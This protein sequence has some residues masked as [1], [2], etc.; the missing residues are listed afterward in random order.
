MLKKPTQLVAARAALEKAE[1]D[2]GDPGRLVY[3]RNAIQV[4]LQ[5]MSGVSPQIEKDIARKQVLISRN[6]VLS[7]VK[8]VVAACD[9]YE[10]GILEHW[11]KVMEVFIDAGLGN[12]AE[13]KACKERLVP[14]R[15]KAADLDVEKEPQAVDSEHGGPKMLYRKSL[16]AIGQSLE[17]LRVQTFK[18]EKEGGSY[19][20]RSDSLTLTHQWFLKNSLTKDVSDTTGLNQKSTQ[21][22]GGD[23]WLC[24]GPLDI[25]RLDAQGQRKRDD[26]QIPGAHKLG[27]CPRNHFFLDQTQ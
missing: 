24:Y 1:E 6:K 4:F 12:D 13:F 11:N 27:V 5:V 20:V 26:Q 17:M 10:P 7:E 25:V 14:K 19:K 21:V 3:L 9:S 2:L 18:L 15:L 22:T 8:V 16:R 23:G